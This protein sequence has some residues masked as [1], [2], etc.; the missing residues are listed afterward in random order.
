[1]HHGFGR[2]VA[3]ISVAVDL[4]ADG[5]KVDTFCG[6]S[7]A[8]SCGVGVW[9]GFGGAAHVCSHTDAQELAIWFE[10]RCFMYLCMLQASR[11]NDALEQGILVLP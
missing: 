2:G 6:L 8:G 1:M 7:N 4:V 11:L 5:D 3:F 10:F 9:C